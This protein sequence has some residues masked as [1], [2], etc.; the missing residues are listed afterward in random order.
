MKTIAAT[1]GVGA[2]DCVQLLP[3]HSQVMAGVLPMLAVTSTATPRARSNAN[4]LPSPAAG[5]GDTVLCA[6]L[7][8]LHCHSSPE[9]SLHSRTAART[10][11][12]VIRTCPRTPVG[13]TAPGEVAGS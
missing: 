13:L 1:G 10:L 8:P 5:C 2:A 11:S 7:P 6:Q 4:A 3:F 12:Q 9:A